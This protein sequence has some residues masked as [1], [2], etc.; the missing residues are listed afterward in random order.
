MATRRIEAGQLIFKETPL[1]V[2]PLHET[3]PVCLVCWKAVDGS[4]QCE[5]CHLLMCSLECAEAEIHVKNECQVFGSQHRPPI[6]ISNFDQFH[7]FYQCIT[8]LR[9]LK[10]KERYPQKWRALKG[11]MD[12]CEDRPKDIHYEVNQKN[13]VQFLRDH[14]N[15][16]CSIEEINHVI[17]ALEVNAFEVSGVGGGRGVFPLTALMS[18]CCISNTRY[19]M[20]DDYHTECRA[21]V[22][23]E[24][25]EEI[26]DFYVSPL[27]GTQYRRTHLRDGWF[28]DCQCIRCQDPTEC[29][30]YQ[31]AHRC[32]SNDCMGNVISLK[33]LDY[34]SDFKCEQCDFLLSRKEREQ[35]EDG[36]TENL[37][38]IDKNDDDGLEKLLE[39]ALLKVQD[40]HFIVTAIKRYLVYIYGRVPGRML[41]QMSLEGALRKRTL[42]RD[43]LT[44]YD[45]I[46]PGLTRERGLTL[47][48]LKSV[49]MYLVKKSLEGFLDL[50]KAEKLERLELCSKLLRESQACLQY[51]SSDTFENMV[52][53]AA[54]KQRRECDD[55]LTIIQLMP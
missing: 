1:T 41:H 44:T 53:Q 6:Q 10:L 20:Y 2:G 43:L 34:D 12:H 29:G 22:T 21:N 4:Y 28:F 8:P 33:P 38:K 50:T 25:G 46:V 15:V 19:T 40:T 51:E 7:P 23:I 3:K 32:G 17:G 47:F 24:V 49:E 54:V 16:P 37:D 35:I 31:D 42:C 30:S 5:K 48:E 27:H 36:L 39:S 18:H 13:V 14:W 11:M 52:Y 45:I 26:T 55:L 9:G